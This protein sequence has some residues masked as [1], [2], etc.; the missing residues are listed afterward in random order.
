MSHDCEFNDFDFEEINE[1]ELEEK[2]ELEEQEKYQFET[3][4]DNYDAE[5]ECHLE[6]KLL[7]SDAVA[8]ENQ[9]VYKSALFIAAVE[10]HLIKEELL[11]PKTEYDSD[12]VEIQLTDSENLCSI[13]QKT[14]TTKTN[15]MESS[16]LFSIRRPCFQ[17]TKDFTIGSLTQL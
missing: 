11:T 13:C 3:I 6:T 8:E 17:H 1:N 16:L 5:F 9:D 12:N 15:S 10:N 14:F 2:D 4:D 7:Q